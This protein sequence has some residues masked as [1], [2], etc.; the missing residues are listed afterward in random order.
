MK[1]AQAGF[2]YAQLPASIRNNPIY[3]TPVAPLGLGKISLLMF[4]TP[5]APLGLCRL[6]KMR[7]L[8]ILEVDFYRTAHD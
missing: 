4:Y 1:S 8:R 2:R 3:A 5:I 6:G 7:D